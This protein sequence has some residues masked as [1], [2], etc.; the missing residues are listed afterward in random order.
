MVMVTPED[1]LPISLLSSTAR[2]L[3]GGA[4]GVPGGKRRS[5][6]DSRTYYRR[7][8]QCLQFE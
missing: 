5:V 1:A 7:D 6:R 2:T 8:E 3:R 4:A